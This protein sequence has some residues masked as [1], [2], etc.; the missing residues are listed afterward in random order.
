MLTHRAISVAIQNVIIVVGAYLSGFY[1]TSLFHVPTSMIGG[2]WAVISG[3]IVIEMTFRETVNSAKVRILG[4]L[5]GAIIS[6]VYLIF[7]PFS[8]VG[9][10]FCIAVGALSGHLLGLPYTIK[11]TGIT[12]SVVMIVS[13]IEHD[14]NPVLNAS[15]RFVESAIGTIIAVFVAYVADQLFKEYVKKKKE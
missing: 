4:S 5:L 12:I 8:L 7:L 14:L 10:A 15:L 9:F 3:I 11:L 13:T 6:G 1:F 2:L